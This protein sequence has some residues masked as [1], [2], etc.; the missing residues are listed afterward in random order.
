MK[1]SSKAL[2]CS[3]L[4]MMVVMSLIVIMSLFQFH[5]TLTQLIQSKLTVV[6]ENI[7]DSVEGAIDLGLSLP[8]LNN[9]NALIVRGK[10]SDPQ[11]N[12]IDI[13]VP[14]G[15][16]LFS[17]APQHIGKIIIPDVLAA[18]R[19]S[20]ERTWG[21][22]NE[23]EFV[24]GMTLTDSIGQAIAGVVLTYSKTGFSN[25]V[26]DFT[27][28]LL[29]SAFIATTLFVGFVYFGIRLCFRDLDQYMERVNDRMKSGY[30]EPSEVNVMP[31]LYSLAD[32]L[33]DPRV[34]EQKIKASVH[35]MEQAYI[36]INAIDRDVAKAEKQ[37]LKDKAKKQPAITKTQT[38]SG[39]GNRLIQR[40]IILSI[41]MALCSM[42]VAGLALRDFN[43]LLTP[44]LGYK[45]RMIGRTVE[46][47]LT[48]A[49][50]YGI[51]FDQIYGA[52]SY[53]KGVVNDHDELIYTAITRPDGTSLYQGGVIDDST[54]I[55]LGNATLTIKN[56]GVDEV[57][58]LDGTFDHIIPIKTVAGTIIG[59][60]HVGIDG[61]FV[62]RQLDDIFF[63]IV[64]ILLSAVLVTFEIMLAMVL[65]YG[66]APIQ[67]LNLLLDR[68]SQGDFSHVIVMH[69]RCAISRTVNRLARDSQALHKAYWSACF[70]TGDSAA[71]NRS[72]LSLI[73]MSPRLDDI[74]TRFG[75]SINGPIPLRQAVPSDIRL[76]LFL[77]AFAEEL[78]K[79]FLPLF[80][81]ELYT[82]VS[83]LNEPIIISLPITVYLAVLAIAAPLAGGW[84]ERYGCRRLFLA[85]LI[86]SVAGFIGCSLA[87]SITEL[88]VWRGVTA[89]GYAMITIGCQD[90]V[91]AHSNAHR[92][93]KNMVLFIGIIMSATMCGTAIGGILADRL[94]YQTVFVLAAMV[95]LFAGITAAYSLIDNSQSKAN[96]KMG[97]QGTHL[98]GRLRATLAVLSNVRFVLFLLCIA[99]PANVLIAAYLWYLVPLYLSD[100]GASASEIARVIMLYYLLIIVVGPITTRLA[101]RS[102]SLALCV[103]L[104]SFLSS[105]G[106]VIFNDWQS[107]W[108]VVISV[109]IIGLT[110]AL[111]KG[112]QIPLALTI[113]SAE[114]DAVGRTTVLGFLRFFERIG[115][116]LG[117]LVSAMIIAHYGY[118]VSIGLTGALVS[119]AALLFLVM[120]LADNKKR[121]KAHLGEQQ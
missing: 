18:Q 53:L 57:I 100:L 109:T 58:E 43:R 48:R 15:E 65:M 8:E 68:L 27:E 96:V 19:R 112:A 116:V 35:Q 59:N 14:S 106:L 11:I 87:S 114:I 12:V 17:T 10:K 21:I 30:S 13:F 49:L 4:L 78:Q 103:G 28:S 115:S 83:W 91:I 20:T 77:F 98:K 69:T 118:A 105:I 52:N 33:P 90:Y 37:Q 107:T 50:S 41:I 16:I 3:V 92:W 56:K 117:I 23:T 26:S 36:Q 29:L 120:H 73:E 82:P 51:P 94:G 38:E 97:D 22:D 81:R 1:T 121:A 102:E 99:I 7:V 24:S 95:A 63:D 86:P 110:H 72:A 74:G 47:D 39:Y 101:D 80:V 6:S 54:L 75:L 79:S 9:A 61:K 113:C 62:Q 84:A 64:V 85:G 108:A 70:R 119:G 67:Q 45:A 32:T 93:R 2:V 71:S 5:T 76:P 60:V 55:S 42:T 104:G 46:A 34:I 31:L 111:T 88:V 89:L 25:K 44:E 40:L 66:T